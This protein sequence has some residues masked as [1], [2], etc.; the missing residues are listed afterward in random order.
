VIRTLIEINFGPL[1]AERYPRFRIAYEEDRD[2][3]AY[4]KAVGVAVNELSLPVGERW[5]REQIGFPAPGADDAPLAGNAGS[6]RS[7]N[8]KEDA[9]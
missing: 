6:N 7:E 4:L 1:P 2:L 8:T 9:E 5:L 3:A